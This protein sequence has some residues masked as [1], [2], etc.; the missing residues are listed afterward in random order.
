MKPALQV[1]PQV[2]LQE[3]FALAGGAQQSLLSPHETPMVA[4]APQLP[5]VR[6]SRPLQQSAGVVQL[7]PVLLQVPQ[8]PLMQLSPEQHWLELVQLTPLA[9]HAAQWLPKHPTPPQQSAAELQFPPLGAQV[10]QLPDLH[11][12]PLQQSDVCPQ[13]ELAAPHGFSHVPFT[14]SSPLQQ[15]LS[16]P[17]AAPSGA[18]HCPD[19]QARGLQHSALVVQLVLAGAH[20]AQVPALQMLEQ[21][22]LAREHV[23]RSGWHAL[24]LPS[25][26]LSP[27][28]HGAPSQLAPSAPH[29]VQIWLAQIRLQHSSND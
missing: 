2:P 7:P 21:Q 25:K 4:H 29:A 27:L 16:A 12:R 26:Q 15:E 19:S 10:L 17:H 5:F 22:S 8:A 20:A 9:A 14:H 24:H 11:S 28:Q 3:L 23:E 6:H 1:K 13:P 18:Q